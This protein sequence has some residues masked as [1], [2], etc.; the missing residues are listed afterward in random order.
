MRGLN[1]LLLDYQS[2]K[3]LKCTICCTTVLTKTSVYQ[4]AAIPIA[5]TT[6]TAKGVGATIL[7]LPG[8]VVVDIG[9]AEGK[10]VDVTGPAAILV[11]EEME[12]LESGLPS[13]DSAD[14]ANLDE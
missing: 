3:N 11:G 14:N 2:A 9:V 5:A 10:L 13:F 12:E 4:K 8:C 1:I 7:P 6:A